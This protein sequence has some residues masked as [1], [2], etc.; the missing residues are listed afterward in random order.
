METKL[1]RPT[2]K[3]AIKLHLV[4]ERYT[5]CNFCSRWSVRKLLDTLSYYMQCR[6]CTHIHL[7]NVE[8]CT[9]TWN[10]TEKTVDWL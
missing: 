1:T 10:R 7:Q 6:S 3:M 9:L 5:I 8:I 2:H 4:A